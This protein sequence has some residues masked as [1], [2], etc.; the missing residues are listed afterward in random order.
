M[1]RL[2]GLVVAVALAGCGGSSSVAVHDDL[3]EDVDP[4]RGDAAR[5]PRPQPEHPRSG[6][7]V[8]LP[9]VPAFPAIDRRR[10]LAIPEIHRLGRSLLGQTVAARGVVIWRRDCVD[11]HAK[12]SIPRADTARYLQAHP[13]LCSPSQLFL[14]ADADTPLGDALWV[15]GGP[16][17][18]EAEVG[19]T[20]TVEGVFAESSP[21]GQTHPGGLLTF[22]RWHRSP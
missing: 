16:T 20:V 19:D 2:A 7:T 6:A 14:G 18:L 1:D 21:S 12:P 4:N 8:A 10:P 3:D 13:E 5:Y 22:G 15:V 11:A 17:V 9:E